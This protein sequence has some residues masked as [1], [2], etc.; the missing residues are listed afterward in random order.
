MNSFRAP[1]SCSAQFT[2]VK[3]E[4]FVGDE[5]LSNIDMTKIPFVASNLLKLTANPA[6]EL[7]TRP[8]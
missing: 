7:L 1:S 2:T 3:H 4:W 5:W 8:N 6:A